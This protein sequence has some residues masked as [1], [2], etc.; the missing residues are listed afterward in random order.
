M[1]DS[2][3]GDDALEKDGCKTGQSCC[4]LVAARGIVLRA[5]HHGLAGNLLSQRNQSEYA[6]D[7]ISETRQF[8]LPGEG[9]CNAK[10]RSLCVTV[11]NTTRTEPPAAATC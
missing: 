2:R 3:A 11:T 1:A 10:A 5:R 7:L 8:A 4:A 6:R 9:G